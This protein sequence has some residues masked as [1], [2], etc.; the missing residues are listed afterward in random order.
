MILYNRRELTKQSDRITT[1]KAP[2]MM[3]MHIAGA[4]CMHRK[5]DDMR[6][7]TAVA[8]K[9]YKTKAWQKCRASYISKVFGLCEH[10]QDPGYI[11]DHIIEI[12]ID[13]INDP[14]ITLSHE[15]LQYLCT[16]CHNKK[17]FTK[18][19]PLREGLGFDED[20]NLIS[21]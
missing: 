21:L 13:N 15:N 7:H 20:G 9:F 11:V 10:C 5:D 17:T 8:K 12:N 19:S 6:Q 18:Y 16:S 14:E 3:H 2:V 1:C 4:F